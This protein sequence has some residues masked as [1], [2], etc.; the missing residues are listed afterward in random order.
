MNKWK[1]IWEK[2][3]A[4]FEGIDPDDVRAMFLE[5]KRADGFD[6]VGDGIPYEELLAQ[7]EATK[8]GLGLDA[9]KGQSVFEVGCGAGA[10]LYLFA[11]EGFRVGGL[12]YSEQ[13]IRIC[14]SVL[15]GG[16]RRSYRVHLRRGC[17][18]FARAAL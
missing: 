10:N 7:Y 11:Q 14:K 15:G 1:A 12:D 8:A 2:R 9:A 18:A 13:L 16:C 5:L 6:V 17:R 3:E 4:A